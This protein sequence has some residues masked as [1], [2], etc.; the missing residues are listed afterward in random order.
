M[1]WVVFSKSVRR[2]SSELSLAQNFSRS[3][4]HFPD[5][6]VCCDWSKF[7]PFDSADVCEA[8]GRNA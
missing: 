7:L 6:E 5:L 8:W 3:K 1:N 4:V 2:S